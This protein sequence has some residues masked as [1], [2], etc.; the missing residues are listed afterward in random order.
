MFHMWYQAIDVEVRLGWALTLS[1]TKQY[2]C[3]AYMN[4]Y[5]L[6]VTNYLTSSANL[7]LL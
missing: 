7:K 2:T 3:E 6:D 1:E 4:T 5:T